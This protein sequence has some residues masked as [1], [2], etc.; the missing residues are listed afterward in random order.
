MIFELLGEAVGSGAR[1]KRVCA[2]LGIALRT[3]ERW[4]RQAGGGR[5]HGIG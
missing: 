1:A 3:L 5:R 2:E 4:Q